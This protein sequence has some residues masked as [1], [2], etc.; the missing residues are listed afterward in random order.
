[1]T[2]T[3]ADAW[4][5]AAASLGVVISGPMRLELEADLAIDVDILFHEFGAPRGTLVIPVGGTPPFW[6]QTAYRAGYA[7]S[8]FNPPPPGYVYSVEQLQYLLSDW[9]WCGSADSKPSWL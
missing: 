6:Q 9:G 2:W 7:I 8:E 1:M 5:L 3:H 4:R